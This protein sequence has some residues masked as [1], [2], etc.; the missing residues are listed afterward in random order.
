VSALLVGCAAA[1]ALIALA[2][3]GKA[4]A[5][6]PIYGFDAS[7]T[8]TQAGGHPD[9]GIRVEVG[10]FATDGVE[11]CF[12]NA[13]RDITVNTP[14]GLIGVPQN[15]A[16]CTASDLTDNICPTDSQVGVV[17]VR[18]FAP[19]DVGGAYFVQPL[20]NMVPKPGELAL[21]A[22]PAP[23]IQ[24]PIYTT[25]S[26]RT[27]SDYGLEFKT[28]GL[29]KLVP[30]NE[31]T[32]ITWGVPADHIHDLQRWNRESQSK[33]ASC[34]EGSPLPALFANEWPEEVCGYGKPGPNSAIAPPTPFLLN[35]TSCEGP[36]TA[37]LD[38]SGYENGREHASAPYPETTGC[39][40][41]G[42]NPSLSA[43][44]TTEEADSP[45]G[46]NVDLKVPQSLSPSASSPSEIRG[47][48]V[49]LPQ[50]LSIDP[51]V[52]NGKSSCTDQEARFGTR[53][54]ASCP[55]Y[56]KIG[57]LTIDSSSLPAP[58]SGSIY[59]GQ[60]LPGNRYRIF[61]I[62][63]GFSLHIKLEGVATPDPQTGRLTV[64][65]KNLPQTPFQEFD[66][67]FFGAEQG[68]LATPTQCGQYEV[69]AEFEPW[70]EA[71]PNQSSRQFF[72]INRGPGGSACPSEP[73]TFR[74]Q[75]VAGITD[76]TGGAHTTF[77]LDLT[78]HDGEQN[79]SAVD[80]A[81]PPGFSGTL[82][83]IPYCSD[84]AITAA[85]SD[86]A[87][88]LAQQLTPSCP[89]G[90][91]VGESGALAGAGSRPVSFPGK[92]YLA[93]PYKGAPLSLA[94]IT[95]AL[96]GPYDLGNVVIRVAIDIDP[97]DAHITAVSDQ[98]PLVVGGIPLRLREVTVLLNRPNFALN[99][100]N[101]AQFAIE[102]KVSGSEGATGSIVNP[103][104]VANC[105]ALPYSPK[106]SLHLNGGVERRGHPAIHALYSTTSG[107]ANTR[108]VSV[109]LPNSE[110]LDNAHIGNIC[111]NVQF[112][113]G[114]CPASSVLGSA[115]ADTPLLSDPLRGKV[116][117]RANPGGELPNLV[118]DLRGQ[119]DIQLVGTIDT[120]H[121]GALRTTFKTVPDAPVSRF[122][123]DLA[124]GSKGLVINGTS[125]CGVAKKAVT[126]LIG[127]NG[128]VLSRRTPLR[129][130][131][132]GKA[133]H[134]RHHRRHSRGRKAA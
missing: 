134:R 16:Q 22:T 97:S 39:D 41:L 93:G 81:T 15:I 73:R 45:S 3:T 47:T 89:A 54:Q 82:A 28:F 131:C 106:L 38:T 128:A 100:T 101:C 32:Q 79:L 77:S 2:H 115:E 72:N 46:L 29:P 50:G 61:L 125:L 44:P 121:R 26:S 122:K 55:E 92:V 91:Q 80:V 58:L 70:D 36:L 23:L 96:A 5:Q 133:K 19:L 84:S 30:P 104:Q 37:T 69:S 83:G 6:V 56:A 116:Y 64:S 111:T 90:S 9:V 88:G 1:L 107:E 120:V 117:L 65:F 8:T 17:A 95:P 99:P 76:N 67:H 21:L 98:L 35:P 74:P 42:F 4:Q 105:G 48:T 126:K 27:E 130:A 31:I 127:Q 114:N 24:T 18:L 109:A 108:V 71:L 11:E 60:P 34:Y 102:A 7:T 87:S 113:A 25:I 85:A 59:L 51:N 49:T 62:A 86:A 124:G 66:L 12:C 57:T 20:Y 94:V 68:L 75:M 119:I 112:K 43:D 13:I 53:E 63:D 110:Q 40:Q 132:S 129:A 14:A 10:T 52:A 78:R 33:S 103:F 118:A 123:L